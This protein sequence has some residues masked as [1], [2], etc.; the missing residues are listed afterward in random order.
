[1]PTQVGGG[2][3]GGRLGPA[4][5]DLDAQGALLF[6]SQRQGVGSTRRDPP[7]RS[8]RP[9][10][11]ARRRARAPRPAP[12]PPPPP[13]PALSDR[14]RALEA[15]KDSLELLHT[16]QY[17]GFLSSVFD[18]LLAQLTSTAPQFERGAELQALRHGALEA[19]SRLP[20]SDAFK[21]YAPR[22]CDACLTV[23]A[24]GGGV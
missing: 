23:R 1:M 7:G 13:P 19:L 24:R 12:P 14:R 2:R 4:Q 3:A 20:A 17:P 22:L 11:R 9:P 15:I 5:I 18:P 21:P 6:G 10:P 16:A 8:P